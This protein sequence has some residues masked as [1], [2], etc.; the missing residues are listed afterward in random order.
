MEIMEVYRFLV[1]I[2]SLQM[3]VNRIA[4]VLCFLLIWLGAK[5]Q[6]IDIQH[7]K[8]SGMG[9]SYFQ[10]NSI[11]ENSSIFIGFAGYTVKQEWANNWITQLANSTSISLK[12]SHL[13]AVKGPDNSL[14]N[15]RE[16]DTKRLSN[17]VDNISSLLFTTDSMHISLVAHSSGAF[18]AHDFLQQIQKKNPELLSRITY[19]CLDGGIGVSANTWTI[20]SD[21]L[22]KRLGKIYPV[23]AFDSENNSWSANYSEMHDLC[24]L[25]PQNT[26]LIYIDATESGC[27]PQAKW[28]LHDALINRMP[29]NKQKFDLKNDYNLINAEHPVAT[30]YIEYQQLNKNKYKAIHPPSFQRNADTSFVLRWENTNSDT[31][32]VQLASEI[33]FNPCVID[34][35]FS[36]DSLFINGLEYE[37]RYFW[38]VINTT[39]IGLFEQIYFFECRTKKQNTEA[40]KEND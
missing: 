3:I 27:N 26:E 19:F 37:K 28:C 32:R 4:S 21:T 24:D 25:S 39:E 6:T 29:H 35:V 23:C 31:V 36:A 20:L 18:V 5:T 34:T 16:I 22:A 7:W 40:K 15:N 17:M 1:S 2:Q 9:V 30:Y 14:F 12:F 10:N 8:P 13:F 11:N 33:G 38:R